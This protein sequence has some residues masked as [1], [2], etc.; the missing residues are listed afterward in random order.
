MRLD[1]VCEYQF[2][3][4]GYDTIKP[5]IIKKQLGQLEATQGPNNTG[6]GGPPTGF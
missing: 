6:F 1:L 5:E 4:A 3:R 2:Y